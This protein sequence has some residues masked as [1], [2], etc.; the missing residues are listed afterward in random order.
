MRHS[1]PEGLY[2]ALGVSP[3]ADP[4]EI[5]LAYR[6]LAKQTH[7]DTATGAS[8]FQFHK[9]YNAYKILSD[10]EAR[11]RYDRRFTLE[12]AEHSWLGIHPVK[13]S[14]CAKVTAQPRALT[15]DRIFSILFFS[16]HRPTTGVFCTRCA[17]TESVRA[18]FSTALFGW[19]AVPSAPFRTLRAIARN[20]MGGTRDREAEEDLLW[21]NS[22]AFAAQGNRKLSY[23]LATK[24]TDASDPEIAEGAR[25]L[26]EDMEARGANPRKIKLKDPWRIKPLA[27]MTHL[28]LAAILPVGI[29]GV[30]LQAMQSDE[31]VEARTR[32]VEVSVPAVNTVA[33]AI[34]GDY[35]PRKPTVRNCW[36]EPENGEVL[37]RI[38]PRVAPGHE[39]S[40]MNDTQQAAIVKV[41]SA[42]SKRLIAAVY[43]YP[44][45]SAALK[46]IPDGY[47]VVQYAFGSILSQGCVTFSDTTAAWQF[48]DTQNLRSIAEGDGPRQLQYSLMSAPSAGEAID[49]APVIFGQN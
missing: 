44:H 2:R 25:E 6:R 30:A 5:K 26:V 36:K 15:F 35:E 7:P 33:A 18:S 14:R 9:I 16:F 34:Q 40:I 31:V 23:A 13:C 12:D 37:Y 17:Q 19:W 11:A 22:R 48:P 46:G 8:E 4:D 41:R 47:Y 32:S 39:I 3:A 21:Q 45:A 28:M 20:A 42:F 10:D 38:N 24:L 1:D 49:V 43:M 29:G 27:A